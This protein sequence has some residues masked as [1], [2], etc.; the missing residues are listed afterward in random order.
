M[1][2]T[3]C[4][5]GESHNSH[6]RNNGDQCTGCSPRNLS[7][8]QCIPPS[9]R[10]RKRTQCI[11]HRVP[12]TFNQAVPFNTPQLSAANLRCNTPKIK[13]TLPAEN[14]AIIMQRG[15][16]LAGYDISGAWSVGLP[17]VG[18]R[19]YKPSAGRDRKMFTM[20]GR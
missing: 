11:S 15:P 17:V 5:D 9:E 12:H 14:T 3:F 20:S 4:Q 2:Q 13:A 7:P 10:D 8:Y 19:E 1:T 16:G 6:F 18:G